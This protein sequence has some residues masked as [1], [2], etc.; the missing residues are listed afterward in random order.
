MFA[1]CTTLSDVI[2]RHIPYISYLVASLRLFLS[3]VKYD[4][5]NMT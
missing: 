3:K 4:K 1:H 2:I 5:Q